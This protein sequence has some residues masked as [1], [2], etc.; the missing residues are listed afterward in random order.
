MIVCHLGFFAFPHKGQMG[1]Y[2]KGLIMGLLRLKV[3]NIGWV[4]IAT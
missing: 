2:V 1:K 4:T 3:T